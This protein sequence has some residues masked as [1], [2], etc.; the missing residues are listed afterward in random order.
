MTNVNLLAEPMKPEIMESVL[1][2]A[3][4]IIHGERRETYGSPTESFTQI[5]DYWSTYI[6][7]LP[8]VNGRVQISPIDVAHMMIL[9]KVSRAQPRYHR[10]NLVDIAGY[11]G[12]VEDIIKET[13]G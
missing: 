12:C 5:G 10:D 3:E 11:A 2:E 9:M 13:H 6:A 8:V 7:R 4:R 1:Q